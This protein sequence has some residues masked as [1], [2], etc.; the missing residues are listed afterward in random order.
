[1]IFRVQLSTSENSGLGMLVKFVADP[2]VWWEVSCSGVRR[3]QARTLREPAAVYIDSGESAP[4][5]AVARRASSNVAPAPAGWSARTRQFTHT[6]RN[7]SRWSG[8]WRERLRSADRNRRGGSSY[9][10]THTL[11]RTRATSP[12]ATKPGALSP[13]VV[14]GHNRRKVH[15]QERNGTIQPRNQFIQK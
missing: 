9:T 10:S 12:L 8:P 4:T 6:P 7:R 11:P 15:T 13:A 5:W 3:T 2:V 14:K 1:M